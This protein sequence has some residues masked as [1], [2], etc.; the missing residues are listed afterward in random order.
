MDCEFALQ[1]ET[2]PRRFSLASVAHVVLMVAGCSSSF[3][4]RMVVLGM[5]LSAA[6]RLCLFPEVVILMETLCE[7]TGRIPGTG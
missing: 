7:L 4:Q 6:G 1:I 3:L 5:R 2:E